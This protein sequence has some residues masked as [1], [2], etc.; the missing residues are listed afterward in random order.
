MKIY[1]SCLAA[2]MTFEAKVVAPPM[3]YLVCTGYI[4]IPS[5]KQFHTGNGNAEEKD[6]G[7]N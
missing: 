5:M 3:H 2:S 1:Q 7:Q 4:H 6:N